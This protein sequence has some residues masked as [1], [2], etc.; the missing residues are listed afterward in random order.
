[1]MDLCLIIQQYESGMS[2]SLRNISSLQIRQDSLGNNPQM[3]LT[4]QQPGSHMLDNYLSQLFFSHQTCLYHFQTEMY[5]K[6]QEK[7]TILA[8]N[9]LTITQRG[10]GG[11][12][13]WIIQ[14]AN[15]YVLPSNT[16]TYSDFILQ[17]SITNIHQIS[18]HCHLKFQLQEL[19]ISHTYNHFLQPL[20]LFM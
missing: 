5:I 3:S 15:A 4:F 20:D 19:I 7:D 8:C 1:M 10:G 14:K 12:Q 13:V 2:V 16:I 9:S 17:K 18:H 11:C 6:I